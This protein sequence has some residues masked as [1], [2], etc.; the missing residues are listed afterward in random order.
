MA[1]YSLVFLKGAYD[2]VV[3]TIPIEAD[4]DVE[5]IKVAS[6]KRQLFAMELK[7]NGQTF[8]RWESLM[9]DR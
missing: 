2:E 3:R 4:S 1:N 5:A 6:E 7:K 8:K 9:S